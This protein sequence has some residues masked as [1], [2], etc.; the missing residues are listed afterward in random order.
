MRIWCLL[1]NLFCAA[2]LLLLTACPQNVPHSPA[3]VGFVSSGISGMV[4]S[5]MQA[6]YARS[7]ESD[8]NELEFVGFANPTALNNALIFGEIDVAVAS[9]AVSVALA[10]AEG[11][12][13]RYLFP[14]V[15]NSAAVVVRSD[16]PYRTLDDLRGKKIGWYG[17]PT[18]G[19][20]GFLM[21]TGSS[22]NDAKQNF[23]LRDAAAPMLPAL[24]SRGDVDA[25]I[26]FE[27][28]VSKLLAG[29]SHRVVQGPF[30]EDWLQRHGY[31]LELSGTAASGKFVEAHPETIQLVQ[32]LWRRSVVRIRANPVSE[33]R[34]YAEQLGLTN[35]AEMA[36]F[37]P[38]ASQILLNEWGS[39]RRGITDSNAYLIQ[40]GFVEAADLNGM[41]YEISE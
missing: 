10:R 37:M 35:P 25:V 28:I 6:E 11:R 14:N 7:C 23:Q 16:S 30:W 40:N 38:V 8:C 22:V 32:S 5:A 15:L 18:A 13:I 27:P 21:I 26:V 41:F 36:Q 17:L 4:V 20:I 2:F 39:V 9:S 1:R 33:T 34:R 31:P 24:L 3:K 29:G 19:G 12:D